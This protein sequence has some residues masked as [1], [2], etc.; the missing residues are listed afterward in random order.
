MS[1]NQPINIGSTSY[2]IQQEF[3][4]LAK[5]Y[6]NIDDLNL[7]KVG[8]FGYINEITSHVAKDGV[9]HRN[10][11]YDE[12]FLNSANFSKSIYNFAKIYNYNIANATPGLM[13]INFAIRKKDIID[14]GD[15][16]DNTGTIDFNISNDNVFSLNR[17]SYMLENSIRLTAKR[18]Q[19]TNDYSITAQYILPEEGVNKLTDMESPHIKVWVESIEGEKWIFLLLDIWQM[20]KTSRKYS[21]YSEDISQN[22]FYNVD[23]PDQ[24]AMFNVHYTDPAGN[25]YALPSYF[26]NTMTPTDNRFCFY[27]YPDNNDLQVGFSA[28]PNSFRPKFNS[29][30]TI[31]V[32]TTAGAEGNFTYTGDILFQFKDPRLSRIQPIISSVT[33]SAGGRNKPSL[34][35]I[36]NVIMEEVLARGNLITEFDLNNFFSG[37]MRTQTINGSK[38]KFVRKR[39]DLIKRLFSAYLLLRNRSGDIIPTNTINFSMELAQLEQ[40]NF[41]IPA[42]TI[43]IYDNILEKYRLLYED[44]YPEDYITKDG[45][46]LYSLPYLLNVRLDPFPRVAYY[47][48]TVNSSFTLSYGMVNPNIN[49]EFIINNLNVVRNS[50]LDDSYELSLSMITNLDKSSVNNNLKVRCILKKDETTYGYFDLTPTDLE[51]YSYST[52]LITDDSFNENANFCIKNSLR[53]VITGELIPE[54]YIDENVTIEIGVLYNGIIDDS[55]SKHDLFGSMVDTTGYSLTSTFVNEK[56]VTIDFF[57]SMTNVM[58]STVDINSSGVFFVSSVPVIST[59]YFSNLDNYTDFYN[60]LDKYEASLVNN[61]DKLENNTSI[62]LKFFNTYGVSLYHSIDKVGVSLDFAIRLIGNTDPGFDISVKNHVVQFVE[63]SN[64]SGVLSISNL[65]TDLETTFKNIHFIEFRNINGVNIQKVVD[66]YPDLKGLNKEQL[67]N[68][69]PEYLNV[70]MGSH[71]PNDRNILT[72]N[73]TIVY[74]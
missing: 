26:N 49:Y 39:D 66:L 8:L 7:L 63:K 52:K 34:K 47:K 37:L 70:S 35:E 43:I 6:Y 15:R 18:Y 64:D 11:L 60:L 44:E 27:S 29:E 22:L 38:I 54:C 62:D 57:K 10:A 72:P 36:K 17:F 74:I 61:F 45:V 14:Y 55:V 58:F 31:D 68:Y 28:L 51:E 56:E 42:G 59:K 20:E 19:D 69:V 3:L 4:E 9:Y 5:K 50:I 48:N 46:V 1:M 21:V 30:L 41:T 23:F 16:D 65:M 33:D 13:K 25:T 32:F 12:Q 71:D 2:D 73:V 67:I 40:N 53:D 24:I